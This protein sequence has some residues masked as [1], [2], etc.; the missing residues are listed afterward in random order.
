MIIKPRFSGTSP[1]GADL[2]INPDDVKPFA[3]V[4]SYA[5][6]TD[7]SPKAKRMFARLAALVEGIDAD[8]DISDA[9]TSY[10]KSY[11]SGRRALDPGWTGGK[12]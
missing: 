1:V 5:A 9:E 6:N 7:L 3:E 12:G 8:I 11:I 2:R 10:S 4:I